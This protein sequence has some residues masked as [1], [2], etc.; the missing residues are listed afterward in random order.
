M[1]AA[2]RKYGSEKF[3]IE[4]VLDVLDDEL[5]IMEEL[6]IIFFQSHYTKGGYNIARGGNHI[7]DSHTEETKNK[8][9]LIKR[10]HNSYELP[11]H[12][13]EIDYEDKNIHGFMVIHDEN[14]YSFTSMNMTMEQKY[15][16]A[17]DCHQQLIVDGTYERTN[18]RKKGCDDLAIPLYISRN[19][20]NGFAV[21]KPGFPRK[22]IVF[23]NNSRQENL[24]LAI[25]YL[26]TLI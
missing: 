7:I 14:R 6:C 13:I 12:V 5:D 24:Y 22:S 11:M 16:Q 1:N 10:I 18:I 3:S 21:N 9:S 8:L 19:G 17:M 2:I 23:K 26:N 4:I 25:E 20:E 15:E